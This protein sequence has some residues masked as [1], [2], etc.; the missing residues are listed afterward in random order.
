[1]K[2]NAQLQN[3]GMPGWALLV[4]ALVILFT[5]ADKNGILK[6]LLTISSEKTPLV[7]MGYL[8]LGL[9]GLIAWTAAKTQNVAITA[10]LVIFSGI[11]LVPYIWTLGG[12]WVIVLVF[13]LCIPLVLAMSLAKVA[14]AV[15]PFT[16]TE[17]G[18]AGYDAL[19]Q[20]Y[21]AKRRQVTGRGKDAPDDPMAT[22]LPQIVQAVAL[23]APMDAAI[24]ALHRPDAAHSLLASPQRVQLP[25]GVQNAVE[26]PDA[27][28]DAVP[29]HHKQS[30]WHRLCGR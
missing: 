12:W 7:L 26:H 24:W 3:D 23:M 21:S 11:A 8:S 2:Q 9:I 27:Y 28:V 6:F 15:Q 4:L 13:L 20:P 17:T 5:F 14:Q 29:R 19:G 10:L 1:M 25:T 18:V 16:W 22:A 30:W